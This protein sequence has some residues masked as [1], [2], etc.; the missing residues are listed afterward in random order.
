MEGTQGAGD[1]QSVSAVNTDRTDE[2]QCSKPCEHCILHK[3]ARNQ[4]RPVD[5]H[6]SGREAARVLLL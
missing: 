5:T 6:S 3:G 1:P 2:R 4:Q